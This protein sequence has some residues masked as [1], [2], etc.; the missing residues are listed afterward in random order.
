MHAHI[1]LCAF[2]TS[3]SIYAL[4][5]HVDERPY[6]LHLAPTAAGYRTQLTDAMI[7]VTHG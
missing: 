4:E 1:K 6:A 7:V 5:V 2:T 3:S